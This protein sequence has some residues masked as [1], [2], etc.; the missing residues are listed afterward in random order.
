VIKQTEAIVEMA[1]ARFLTLGIVLAVF[2]AS[3]G[4]EYAVQG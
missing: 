2:F 1:S 4:V 3:N